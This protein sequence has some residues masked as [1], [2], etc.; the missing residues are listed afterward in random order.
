MSEFLSQFETNL[1]DALLRECKE[2]GYS[3]GQLLIAE[4][5]EEK[6]AEIAPEYM[7]DA[8][9]NIADYPTVA[10]A[11][12]GY[13]G[14]G[15]AAI[16]DS[17]EWSEFATRADAYFYMRGEKGFDYMDE[18]IIERFLGIAI[19][20]KEH[21]NLEA[22][23]RSCANRTL[24]MIRAEKIEPQSVEAFHIFAAATKVLFKIG[25]SVELKRL[26]YKYEKVNMGN[27]GNFRIS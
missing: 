7:V 19:E 14:M 13:I 27:F 5:M 6:W 23:M 1:T 18:Y 11:W 10:I 12:A 17:E 9:P 8:V 4:E 26:G 21:G 24:T 25:V 3:N 22:L 15:M 16:W 20:S 2:A